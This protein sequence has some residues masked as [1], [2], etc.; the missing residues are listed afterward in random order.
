M[1]ES[2]TPD[3]GPVAEYEVVWKSGYVDRV[4]AHQVTRLG[5]STLFSVMGMGDQTERIEFHGEFDGRWQLVLSAPADQIATV[6][7]VS[8]LGEGLFD[9]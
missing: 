7:N 5:G 1:T 4:K 6:R 2:T 3:R 9:E 8:L